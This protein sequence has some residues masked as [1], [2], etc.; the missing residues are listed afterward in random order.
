MMTP[1]A[2]IQVLAAGTDI[3]ELGIDFEQLD[4]R[5]CPADSCQTRLMAAKEV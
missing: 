5:D 4:A 3:P 1:Y 2:K